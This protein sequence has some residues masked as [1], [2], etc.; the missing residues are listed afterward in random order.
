MSKPIAQQ[1]YEKAK[2]LEANSQYEEVIDVLEKAITLLNPS[3]DP[4]LSFNIFY[5]I[6]LTATGLEIY[7]KA[8]EAFK[9]AIKICPEEL[10][11]WPPYYGLGFA[12]NSA[13]QAKEAI[14]PFE[15]ALKYCGETLDRYHTLMELSEAYFATG[16][17]EKTIECKKEAIALARKIGLLEEMFMAIRELGDIYIEFDYN[18]E[19]RDLLKSGL[20]LAQ[21]HSSSDWERLFIGNLSTAYLGTN[22]LELSRKM[23]DELLKISERTGEID[24][25]TTA[26]NN[27][28]MY[29]QRKG[30]YHL[31]IDY[32]NRAIEIEDN[33]ISKAIEYRNLSRFYEEAG[34]WN[35]AIFY[36]LQ[37]LEI[38]EAEEN[39]EKIVKYRFQAADLYF[40]RENYP[41]AIQYYESCIEAFQRYPENEAL[42]E[43]LA[44]L[45][46]SWG[47]LDE[48]EKGLEYFNQALEKSEEVKTSDRTLSIVYGALAGMYLREDYF[49]EAKHYYLLSQGLDDDPEDIVAIFNIAALHYMT[50]NYDKA[51]KLISSAIAIFE[52]QR[53]KL[54]GF[55]RKYFDDRNGQLYE[56]LAAIKARQGEPWQ[57]IEA[58]EELKSRAFLEEY[59]YEKLF[60]IDILKN[61][62]RSDE[63]ILYYINTQHNHP[64]IICI[65]SEEINAI[66]L[67]LEAFRKSLGDF[68][69][70]IDN[71]F[72]KTQMDSSTSEAYAKSNIPHP[73]WFDLVILYYRNRLIKHPRLW[74]SKRN[75]TK[76]LASILYDFLIKRSI[77]GIEGKTRITIIPDR[78]LSLIPFE[79]LVNENNQ[80]LV[81]DYIFSYLPNL[82]LRHIITKRGYHFQKDGLVIG[83]SNYLPLSANFTKPVKSVEEIPLIRMRVKSTIQKKKNIDLFYKSIGVKS[84]PEL[85]SVPFEIEL[86][87]RILPSSDSFRESEVTPHWFRQQS[88]AGKLKDYRILHF[89]NHGITFPAIPELSALILHPDE[90]GNRYINAQKI[91]SLDIAADLIYLSACET[92][93]G[94]IIPSIGLVGL[95]QAFFI[96]GAKSV[97][98]SMWEIHDKHSLKIMEC[99][100][101]E[102]LLCDWDYST[103]LAITKRKCLS[104]QLGEELMNPLYW[105]PIIWFGYQSHY[106]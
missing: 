30:E 79:S 93:L 44:H 20:D 29:H 56:Y 97:Q 16:G 15:S 14:E 46:S 12:L 2:E 91:A 92:G 39:W 78:S 42:V 106:N 53:L 105:S 32:L 22:E 47:R 101:A 21:R 18:S 1:L 73:G 33:Q 66:F 8:I 35:S 69:K 61:E 48:F 37:A 34:D 85:P 26:F 71:F 95:S 13:E 67:S 11:L 94:E 51:E 104:G 76:R 74:S 82:G 84:W 77:S 70:K 50:Q 27:L 64:L 31:G 24:D 68:N 38:V 58:I 49:E 17:I 52:R 9:R 3:D 86:F 7:S 83:V 98:V 96:A 72:S 89:A 55:D 75:E 40:A 28:A 90:S 87:Q 62:I 103:A 19:A 99:Y 88:E 54:I 25:K 23:A 4:V 43:L 59:G 63:I 65:T 102:L 10:S 100:Y 41:L 81:E 6:G 45:G 60:D 57:T 80:Y 36:L 5:H